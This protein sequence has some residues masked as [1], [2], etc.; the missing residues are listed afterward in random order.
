MLFKHVIFLKRNNLTCR[1]HKYKNR[2]LEAAPLPSSLSQQ[3]NTPTHIS[4]KNPP[5]TCF[6]LLLKHQKIK[7]ILVFN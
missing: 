5:N 1:E 2:E 7:H 3:T 6:F 4:L